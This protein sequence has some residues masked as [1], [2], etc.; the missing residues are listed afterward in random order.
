[1]LCIMWSIVI[2]RVNGETSGKHTKARDCKEVRLLFG[3][4]TSSA[5]A[6]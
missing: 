4:Y 5:N 6:K 2:D 3:M 1:M